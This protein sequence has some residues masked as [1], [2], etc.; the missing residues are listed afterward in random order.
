MRSMQIRTRPHK[1]M[2]RTWQTA[3]WLTLL[4]VT[5]SIVLW[6]RVPAIADVTNNTNEAK[7]YNQL[8]LPPLPEVKIPE[9][10]R[11]QLKNGL[12][13]YLVEDHSLPL[14][15]GS[16]VLRTGSRLEP[17]DK[18]GL[19]GIVG[20]VMRSGGTKQH[21]ADE[22]NQILEQ[23][24]ASVETGMDETSGS[25]SFNTLTENLEQVFGL[26]AEV[27]QEPAFADDKLELAKNQTKSSI[28]RRND[29]PGDITS[30]EF[31]KLIYGQ[32]SPYARTIEY[33]TIDNITRQDVVGF[34][35][36]Y[37]RPEQTILG[38]VGDFDAA[39]MKKSIDRHFGNWQV[40]TAKPNLESP[41]ATQKNAS[42]VF[43]V[44]QSQLT[45]SNVLL[46]HLGGKLDSP[47]YPALSVLNEVLN[48]FG[49]RL[50][51]E[52]RSRQGLAYSV[53]G[54][55][56]PRYDYP[57]VFLAGGQTRS[58]ATVA[59]VQA[60]LAEIEKV[61]DL[62]VTEEELY[63]AK[64]SI[65]NS[66]VFNFENPS[67]TMGRLMRYEY[68]GYPKDFIFKYQQGV[69]N[70]TIKDIQRVAQTYLQ[71]EKI[72]TLVVGNSQQIQ[73]SLSSLT[74]KVQT[75]DISIPQ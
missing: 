35:Q 28:A 64:E 30:R 16:A 22:L 68:F 34:Y 20:T 71:P 43:L 25:A 23:I 31:D 37:I 67:Q 70:T 32:D 8:Q 26:F 46:G 74:S 17:Q 69:K 55:W 40:T 39:E 66:F 47:D 3:L 12:V 60:V 2:K 65:L 33:K 51:N 62:P 61:R 27:V 73:P 5:M 29:S 19:A 7:P 1:N 49:G 6:S 56:S 45:Q 21:K 75:V 41:N 10:D 24:A 18:V 9:Y 38:I 53:Y 11:Y 52:V 44:E 42:G 4:L 63:K 57:G 36:K 15:S 54:Y 50:F 58:E 72:V 48:G 14:V 59:F 13:V